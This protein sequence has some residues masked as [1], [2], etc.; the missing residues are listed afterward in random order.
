MK[1]TWRRVQQ[2][3]LAIQMHFL[4]YYSPQIYEIAEQFPDV[5]VILDHLGRFKEGTAADFAAL[6]KLAKLPQVYMKYSNAGS[7]EVKSSVRKM[8]DAFGPDRMIWGYFGHDLPTFEKEAALLDAM[9]DYASEQERE[10]I[11]GGNA[12]RL[13]HWQT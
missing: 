10:K 6:L 5:P 11:R 12:L 3:K 9:F 7:I 8:Y 4:P 1:A 13:F 2:L